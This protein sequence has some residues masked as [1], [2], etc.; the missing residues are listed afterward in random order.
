[1]SGP[2]L[3]RDYLAALAAQLPAPIVSELEDAL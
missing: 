2:G 1:M 3:I